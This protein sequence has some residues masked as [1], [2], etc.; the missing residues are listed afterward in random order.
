MSTEDDLIKAMSLLL[1][2]RSEIEQV[3]PEFKRLQD[4]EMRL[5]NETLALREENG[6]LRNKIFALENPV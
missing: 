6:Q 1:S 3:R 2:L 5:I 4:A